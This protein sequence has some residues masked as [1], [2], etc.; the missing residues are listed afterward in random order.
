LKS[1]GFPDSTNL[2]LFDFQEVT[3]RHEEYSPGFYVLKEGQLDING[4]CKKLAGTF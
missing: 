3:W 2:A 4:F 1:L